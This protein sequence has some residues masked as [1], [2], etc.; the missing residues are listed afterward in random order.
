MD[1]CVLHEKYVS[2]A[3]P[4]WASA[5]YRFY[6]YIQGKS[7]WSTAK[8]RAFMEVVIYLNLH[9]SITLT[10]L[11]F[12]HTHAHMRSFSKF[13]TCAPQSERAQVTSVCY[14]AI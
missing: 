10:V 9:M 14:K 8:Y 4:L 3:V 7:I 6:L 1:N 5:F 13:H 11:Q 12:S 2:N